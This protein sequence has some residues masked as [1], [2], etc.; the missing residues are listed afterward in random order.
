MV[1]NKNTDR[2][3]S[4][5]LQ[6]DYIT[7]SE[8]LYE[9]NTTIKKN[10]DVLLYSKTN[11]LK[12]L[13][14]IL[15]KLNDTYNC[16]LI[17]S[18]KISYETLYDNLSND[19]YRSD[20]N[21]YL[22][23]S[24][25]NEDSLID[26]SSFNN[27]LQM[28][29]ISSNKNNNNLS[30]CKETTIEDKTEIE[31]LEN[32]RYLN[33]TSIIKSNNTNFTNELLT[34]DPF[35]QIKEEIIVLCKLVGFSNIKNIIYLS[36]NI[37][38]FYYT[39]NNNEMIELLNK[40]FNPYD[41]KYYISNT[42]QIDIQIE[43]IENNSM[44]FNNTCLIKIPIGNYLFEIKGY[45]SNDPLLIQVRTSQISNIT[46]Y[47]KKQ[48]FHNIITKSKSIKLKSINNDFIDIYIK[49]MSTYDMLVLNENDF[50]NKIYDDYILFNDLCKMQ[51]TKLIKIFTKDI[52]VNL[53]TMYNIIRLLLLGNDENCGIASLLFNL[54]KDKKSSITNFSISDLIYEQLN[55]IGQRKLKKSGLN[56]KNEI[57]KIKSISSTDIDIKKQIIM[58]PNM[59]D[60]VRKIC[61]EKVDELKNS[62]SETYKLKM[63]INMLVQFPWPSIT[64]DSVFQKISND[65]DA[66]KQFLTNVKNKLDDQIYGHKIAKTRTIQ[67]LGKLLSVQGSA[68]TPM[69]LAGPPG[70]GKTKFAQCLS[71]C[72][73]IPFVQITLGG[74]N[75]GELLHGHGYTYSGA[76]PGMIVKKMIEAGSSRCIM[77]FDE[78]DKCVSKNGQVNEIMSI[79]IHLTDPMTNGA[80]QDRFFQEVSFPLNKV[81]FMF[82]FNDISKIDKILLDRLEIIDVP[83]YNINDKLSIANN[84]LIKQLSKDIGFE[85]NSIKFNQDVL[86]SLIDNYTFEPGVRSLKRKLENIM[87]KL[88]VDKIFQQGYFEN[89][90]NYNV[91]EP[92]YITFDKISEYLGDANLEHKTI[93]NVNSIG[94]VN[95]LYATSACS[96]GIVPIQMCSY[97]FGKDGKFTLRL[98]GNQQKIMKESV[99][100][101]FTTAINLLTPDGKD[102]FYKK[103][104]NGV[105]VH[106]PEAAT[107]KD[108]PSAGVSFTLCFLSLMLDL[109]IDREIALTGEIDLYGNVSKIGGVKYKMQGGYKAGVKTIFLPNDNKSDYDLVLQE[110]ADL[111]VEGNKCLFMSHVYDV[112]KIA[113][114]GFDSKKHLLIGKSKQNYLPKQ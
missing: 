47:N 107:P 66:S 103:Y 26:L 109:P 19:S 27:E 106:T 87:L 64:D 92:L 42:K 93:H 88:N 100:C 104:H 33:I 51:F 30:I 16:E 60:H 80:F 3:K 7:L 73:D 85:Y 28:S 44:L 83:S 8:I 95:G 71:E 114:I 72:L 46:L 67:T 31:M 14:D 75:D 2:L 78:L 18:N 48:E 29:N 108:G 20:N 90:K 81:I 79:L 49:N 21:T 34:Y 62:N 17:E 70:V 37:R 52:D 36:L 4:L 112:A 50:I 111:F 41:Y 35:K 54:L 59:P 58:T 53:N 32:I 38:N 40:I 6:K 22:S 86:T 94:I 15:S 113:L 102:L 89:N 65:R 76:Q 1:N 61:L 68:I 43:R 82:S 97:D 13:N 11:S 105:H 110:N 99:S 69:A 91:N 55:Y 12:Q 25:S 9:I 96:G 23:N 45:I 77:Y 10:E 98:T 57:D 74:Q 5:I 39:K 63:Y 56:I 24:C 84:Y 101:A